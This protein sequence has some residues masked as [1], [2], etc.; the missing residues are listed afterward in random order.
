VILFN[1][2]SL[3]NDTRWIKLQRQTDLRLVPLSMTLNGPNPQF[4]VR[5]SFDVKYLGNDIR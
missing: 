1:V 5:P 3:E 4:K 2:K